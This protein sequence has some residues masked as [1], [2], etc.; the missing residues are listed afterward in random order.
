[1]AAVGAAGHTCLCLGRECWGGPYPR[2]DKHLTQP[3]PR[4]SASNL[5]VW[6]HRHFPIAPWPN[7][8][9]TFTHCYCFIGE[10]ALHCSCT[11]ITQNQ[12]EKA[13][14]GN[15]LLSTHLLD[16]NI[17]FDHP[18]N[19]LHLQPLLLSHLLGPGGGSKPERRLQ[20]INPASL[21]PGHPFSAHAACWSPAS[22]GLAGPSW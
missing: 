17:Q 14:R 9:S 11:Q 8:P 12:G 3:S 10:H 13:E 1:M 2:S 21:W 16:H 20:V 6:E 18:D 19:L 4:L 7:R 15:P 22:Q 5:G